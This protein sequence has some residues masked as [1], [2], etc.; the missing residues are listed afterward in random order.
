MLG[1]NPADIASFPLVTACGATTDSDGDGITTARE[2]CYY[3]TN[4][5]VANT[6][7]DPCADGKEVAWINA[8][9]TVNAT[10]LSQVAQ[11]FGLYTVPAAPH[12]INFDITKD[13]N[14][15]ATDLSQVA[16]R[17]GRC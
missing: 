11:G 7:G 6:D 17:F 8:D 16:Q 12:L 3:N 14:I 9:L 13:G 15:N 10:D 4:P 5:N 2:I 1:T